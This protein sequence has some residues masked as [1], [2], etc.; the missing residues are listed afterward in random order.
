MPVR[1]TAH[2][3]FDLGPQR[4]DVGVPGRNHVDPVH[5][6]LAADERLQRVQVHHGDLAPEGA[7]Q[8]A[9]GEQALHVQRPRPPRRANRE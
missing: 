1:L 2:A 3:P 7:R 6:L 4:R 8:A 5:Q 9:V